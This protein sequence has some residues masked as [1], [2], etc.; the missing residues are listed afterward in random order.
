[1]APGLADPARRPRFLGLAEP[2]WR[3]L[4][5]GVVAGIWLLVAWSV[6]AYANDCAQYVRNP[7][8]FIGNMQGLVEDCMRTGYVQA[9]ATLVAGGIGGGAIAM[10]V[11]NMLKNA[12]ESWKEP[13]KDPSQVKVSHTVWENDYCSYCGM[14]LGDNV[15]PGARCPH[16]GTANPLTTVGLCPRCGNRINTSFGDCVSCKA[17]FEP[18]APEVPPVEKSPPPDTTATVFEND[19]CISCGAELPGALTPG[20]RCPACKTANPVTTIGLCP[21]CGSRINMDTG[22]CVGCKTTFDPP[23]PDLPPDGPTSGSCRQCGRALPTGISDGRCPACGAGIPKPPPADGEGS[24]GGNTDSTP[25]DSS[26]PATTTASTPPAG[27]PGTTAPAAAQDPPLTT[28]AVI[29]GDKAAQLLEQAGLANITRDAEGK[30]I[31]IEEAF[32]GAFSQYG[33]KNVTVNTGSS[34]GA[35]GAPDF[36]SEAKGEITGIAFGVNPDGSIGDPVIVVNQSES[37][38]RPVPPPTPDPFTAAIDAVK[39]TADNAAKQAQAAADAARQAYAD[40]KS[41]IEMADTARIAYRFGKALMTPEELAKTVK[42]LSRELG[43]D[44]AKAQEILDMDAKTWKGI[45]AAIDIPGT[46]LGDKP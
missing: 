21:K 40:A 23:T 19:Y 36:V 43:V 30:V 27:P 35:G 26:A 11:G 20:G 44:P 38:W 10:A 25:A 22:W 41:K 15:T 39:D 17:T 12:T 42:D 7:A 13:V 4:I 33:G 28:T 9:A 31:R 18:P 16:C 45:K 46:L 2:V 6:T 14:L 1:M 37:E 24:S 32:P 3:I 5:S 8:N 34:P 29:S